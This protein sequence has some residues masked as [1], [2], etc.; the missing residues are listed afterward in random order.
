H[1]LKAGRHLL[2]LI[3]EIL[4]LAK[5]ESGSVVLSLEPVGMSDMLQE[6]QS[7]VEPMGAQRNIRLVFPPTN[8]LYVMA[9]RTRL[10]QV[11]LNLLSNAIKYNRDLGTVIVNCDVIDT[12]RV[13]IAVQDTGA[14]LR[15]EQIDALFQPFNR[16]GQETGV[17]E[18]TGIGLVVTKRLVELMGGVISVSSTAGIGSVFWIDLPATVPPQ[19]KIENNKQQTTSISNTNRREVNHPTLLYIED[20]PANLKLVEEL[21]RFRSD[22]RL[23]SAPEGHLGIEL[24]RTHLP[25]LILMDI[26]LPGMSGDDARKVLQTSPKTAHIPIIAVTANA[27]PH[28]IQ[29]G[30]DAGF[31]RYI[32][33]PI[34]I[35][36][37]TEAIDS[38]LKLATSRPRAI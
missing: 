22:L 14:G 33:K 6:C 30:L 4:D 9:D 12:E 2:T 1:I 19:S 5:V 18:G 21:V 29:K 34:N 27:L 20:N 38:A 35:E 17:E 26:N 25:D 37:F 13:R 23:I 8:D 28:D 24:A 10:K 36:E 11:M 3:N 32:T 31:Y 7:M 15:P 16:L